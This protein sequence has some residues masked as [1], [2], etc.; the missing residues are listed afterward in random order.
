[1]AD[2]VYIDKNIRENPVFEFKNLLDAGLATV[3]H[4]AGEHWTD[5]N[6]HDP[7]VTILEQLCYAL[8]E[9]G[10]RADFAFEDLLA[11]QYNDKNTDDTYYTV[12]RILPSGPITVNDLRKLL[13]DRIDGLRNVWIEPLNVSKARSQKI[14]RAHV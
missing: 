14:G 6:V 1:M 3:Q 2:I 12:A 10:Y 11:S 9:L 7:G 8:T 5:Y 13:I 4:M